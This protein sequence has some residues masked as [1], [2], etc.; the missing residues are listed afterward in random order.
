MNGG[1]ATNRKVKDNVYKVFSYKDNLI[2]SNNNLVIPWV[3]D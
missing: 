3:S 2:Q 1:A